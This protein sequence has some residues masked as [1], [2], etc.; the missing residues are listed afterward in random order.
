MK[1]DQYCY[2]AA[3]VLMVAGLVGAAP[4]KAAR[5]YNLNVNMDNA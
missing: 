5:N 3:A 4:S 1:N 2:F